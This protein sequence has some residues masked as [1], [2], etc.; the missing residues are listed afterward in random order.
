[1]AKGGVKGPPDHSGDD[2]GGGGNDGQVSFNGKKKN[3][4]LIGNELN[5]DMWGRRES[6]S[7]SWRG[8]SASSCWRT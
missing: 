8:C 5:N 1:M 3:D 4:T 6:A 2:D 7:P